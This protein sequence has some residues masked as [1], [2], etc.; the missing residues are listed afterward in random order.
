MPDKL[1][2]CIDCE[3]EFI[4]TAGEQDFYSSRGLRVPRRC[5]SCRNRGKQSAVLR[6]I[7][8]EWKRDA[9]GA[10]NA[11]KVLELLFEYGVIG[12]NP[13]VKGKSIF[14]YE[15]SNANLNQQENIIIHRGLY[16]ALQIF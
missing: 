11:T 13:R 15:Y 16:G 4:F 3:K 5:Q 6:T 2:R 9:N 10:I 1:I 12:N 8:V 14:R 7:S